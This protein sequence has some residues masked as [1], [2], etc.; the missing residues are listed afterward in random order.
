MNKTLFQGLVIVATVMILVAFFLPWATVATS[1][2]GISKSVLGSVA[3]SP[4]AGTVVKDIDKVTNAVSSMGDISV[5][6][7]VSGYQVPKLVN[8]DSSKVA[9]SL[10]Q[11]MFK[12][13]DN[14]DKKSYLVY[15]MPLLALACSVLALSV[16]KKMISL[17]LMIFISGGVS[18][19]GLYNLYTMDISSTIVKIAIQKG[20]W[21]T[22]YS[23]LF[24]FLVGIA[25]L[26]LD[27]KTA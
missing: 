12:S 13:A 26:V 27:K 19:A 21:Y 20:L 23:F 3:S 22:M 14:V 1:V 16:S 9:L 15:L 7:T 17:T 6:T 8:D 24:I 5:K 10:A 18:I 25:W 4:L 11:I 2:T